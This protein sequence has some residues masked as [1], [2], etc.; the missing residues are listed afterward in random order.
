MAKGF[1]QTYGIDY[2]ETFAPTTRMTTI[3]TALT[4]AAN[5]G[6]LVHHMDVDNAFLNADLKEDIYMRLPGNGI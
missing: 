3:L 5:K 2:E 4:L 6:W 1:T